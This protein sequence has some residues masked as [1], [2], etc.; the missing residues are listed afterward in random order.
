MKKKANEPLALISGINVVLNG[1]DA[2]MEDEYDE[3]CDIIS[4]AV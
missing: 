4:Q 3:T 1:C 2:M